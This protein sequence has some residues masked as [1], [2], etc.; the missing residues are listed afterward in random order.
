VGFTSWIW[1]ISEYDIILVI[2]NYSSSLLSNTERLTS[3]ID[4]KTKI[5]IW[6]IFSL[7]SQNGFTSPDFFFVRLTNGIWMIGETNKVIII[8][9]RL[10]LLLSNAQ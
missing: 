7:L 10:S 1:V 9:I 6:V 3:H 4:I 2:N 8:N 5:T